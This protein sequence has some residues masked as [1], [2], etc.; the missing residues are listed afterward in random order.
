[1]RLYQACDR[2]DCKKEEYRELPSGLKNDVLEK[3]SASSYV[4]TLD[5]RVERSRRHCGAQ[6]RLRFALP[7]YGTLVHYNALFT[8]VGGDLQSHLLVSGCPP[9]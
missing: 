7:T 3:I 2:E 8:D 1:M 6:R 9:W 5:D 4:R